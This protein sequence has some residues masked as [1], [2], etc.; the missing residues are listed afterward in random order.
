MNYRLKK[1]NPSFFD[2][3][4]ENNKAYYKRYK[5]RLIAFYMINE[6]S[7]DHA[8]VYLAKHTN[9][10]KILDNEFKEYI[11]EIEKL[12]QIKIHEMN[13]DDKYYFKKAL[14]N[15]LKDGFKICM[16]C[17]KRTLKNQKFCSIACSNNYKLKS[18]DHYKKISESLKKY[19]KNADTSERNKKISNSTTK[20]Y[21]NLDEKDKEYLKI[22]GKPR[23]YE[24]ITEINGF[25]IENYKGHDSTVDVYCKKHGFISKMNY[26]RVKYNSKY[27]CEKCYIESLEKKYIL[28][29]NKNC[30]LH[31]LEFLG[32]LDR[33]YIKLKCKKHG[34]FKTLM[35]NFIGHRT[36]CSKCSTT[37][38]ELELQNLVPNCLCN[39]R[40]IID[41]LELDIYSKEHNFAIEYDGIIYH[42]F[43]KSKYTKFNN[44]SKLDKNK[45]LLKTKLCE[46]K[47]I[48]LFHIFENEWLLKSKIWTSVIL[49]KLGLSNRI[50]ARKCTIK[51]ISSKEARMF[52]ENNHLQGS[53]NSSIRIGLF[54]DG[55]LVQIMTFGASRFNKK[56]EYELLRLCSKL[57]T[58]V[59][60][61]ASKILK[62]FERNYKPKSL[63]SYANRRWSNGNLYEK[64]GFSFLHATEPNYFYVSDDKLE[65]RIKY[66]KHKLKDLLD[67]FDEKLTE[68]ENMLNNGYRIIYDCGN[69][70]YVKEY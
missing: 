48:Q 43:G 27:M 26:Q 23:T 19:Y 29:I 49:N 6:Y 16:N 20:Y 51:E 17:G 68:T 60:G 70:V 18:E 44:I 67:N 65:S 55:E 28:E 62:Y 36:G 56:Y 7:I 41:P 35:K 33:Y 38:A 4:K 53:I 21:E 15:C 5:H 58:T 52:I 14:A 40:N 69:L 8:L 25:K 47:G 61:G 24:K 13:S 3:S 10:F 50:Y 34:E 12:Y 64:L 66:Q 46:E 30:E 57:N 37:K 1:Y 2:M 42:S 31:N 22:P 39:S 11:P 45:H 59:V 9:I 32:F 54:R 63:L